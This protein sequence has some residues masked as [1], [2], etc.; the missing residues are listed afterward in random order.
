MKLS[1][2]TGKCKNNIPKIW[3]A[4]NLF[5]PGE[6]NVRFGAKPQSWLPWRYVLINLPAHKNCSVHIVTSGYHHFSLRKLEKDDVSISVP[7]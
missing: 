1:I 3:A 7:P 5:W 4:L 6:M 2:F